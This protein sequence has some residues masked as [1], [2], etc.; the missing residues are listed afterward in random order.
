M[1]VK[2]HDSL[3]GVPSGI[4]QKR[5]IGVCLLSYSSSTIRRLQHILM[6]KVKGNDELH[7]L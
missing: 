2:Y 1:W 6:P 3:D 7:V 5:E 4:A